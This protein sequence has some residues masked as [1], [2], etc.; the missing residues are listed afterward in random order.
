MSTFDD[1][2]KKMKESTNNACECIDLLQTALSQN[3]TAHL[4]VCREKT[5]HIK[6]TEAELSAKITQL[7]QENN[8]LRVYLSVP[9]ILQRIG[10]HI[11][12]LNDTFH[13][14]IKDDILFSDR[15]VSELTTL[16]RR[17]KEALK[18][19]SDLLVTKNPVLVRHITECEEDVVK[20]ALEFATLHEERLIEGLCLPVSSP[21]YLNILNSIRCIAWDTNEI[22]S[23]FSQ[24]E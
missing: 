8:A 11:D 5:A 15:A 3:S 17:L 24:S 18:N 21:L 19:T 16:F 9:L 7:A 22:A 14:K 12:N 6:K 2:V 20:K 1:F 23:K 4:Q 10:G 13:K